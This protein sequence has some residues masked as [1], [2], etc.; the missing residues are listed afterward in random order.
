MMKITLIIRKG[1]PTRQDLHV[2]VNMIAE[3][4]H[5][6]IEQPPGIVWEV[7][8]GQIELAKE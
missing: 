7:E 6:G 3:G 8:E 5:T 1:K 4:Y 2:I